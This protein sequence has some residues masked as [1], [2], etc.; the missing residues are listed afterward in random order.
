MNNELAWKVDTS[1]SSPYWRRNTGLRLGWDISYHKTRSLFYDAESNE[2]RAD[3]LYYRGYNFDLRGLR[4]HVQHEQFT[5]AV[6]LAIGGKQE[7]TTG[8]AGYLRAGIDFTHNF[9]RY[10]PL[11]SAFSLLKL[12]GKG[13]WGLRDRAAIDADGW[14][15]LKAQKP[16]FALQGSLNGNISRLLQLRA[17][18]GVRNL[19]PGLRYQYLHLNGT[20]IF[21][22]ELQNEFI[23]DFGGM[24]SIP[25]LHLSLSAFQTLGTNFTYFN[26]RWETVQITE[27]VVITG[28]QGRWNVALGPLHLDNFIQWQRANF[29]AL[30][31]PG[32]GGI[33]SLYYQQT[34]F[35]RHLLFNVG[36]DIQ[37][38]P[39]Y[40]PYGYAPLM[41]SLYVPEVGSLRAELDADFF[42]SFK[43]R[44]LRGFVRVE[45]LS[46]FF[47]KKVHY[48]VYQYPQDKLGIR[49]GFSWLFNN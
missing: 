47:S 23:T 19:Y 26:D 34:A 29:D 4:N 14:L 31:L 10:A 35:N 13:H 44:L 43:I 9:L 5:N 45:N 46:N 11:D 3:T 8:S 7:D 42:I 48:Q 41:Q 20:R 40:K 39:G 21:N 12:T 37:Y 15:L 38:F 49:I 16:S 30:R 1:G 22:N 36:F 32:L 27:A 33:H 6:Y 28:L 2:H 25:G 24:I 18:F 17:W